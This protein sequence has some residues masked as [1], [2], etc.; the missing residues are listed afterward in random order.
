[1]ERNHSK[2]LAVGMLSWCFFTFFI[3]LFYPQD[4]ALAIEVSSALVNLVLITVILITFRKF[5]GMEYLLLYSLV[6][7]TGIYLAVLRGSG[8]AVRT[9]YMVFPFYWLMSGTI[10]LSFQKNGDTGYYRA[11]MYFLVIILVAVLTKNGGFLALAVISL[12]LMALL[13]SKGIIYEAIGFNALSAVAGIISVLGLNLIP[14]SKLPL[15][16]PKPSLG[17]LLILLQ[18]AVYSTIGWYLFEK[19]CST[20]YRSRHAPDNNGNSVNEG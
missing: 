9:L 1:M 5:I 18:Q 6:P 12:P 11:L 10:L 19:I 17:V 20:R 3:M 2:I 7:S 16:T 14:A 13:S 4:M 8:V 15:S